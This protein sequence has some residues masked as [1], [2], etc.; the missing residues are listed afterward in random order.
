VNHHLAPTTRTVEERQIG[1]L[2][3]HLRTATVT[4]GAIGMAGDSAAPALRADAVLDHL[5]MEGSPSFGYVYGTF[6]L[7]SGAVVRS[8]VHTEALRAISREYHL[9]H[10]WG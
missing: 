10:V 2:N 1:E 9:R 5:G 6:R 4:A 7:A 8:R 3:A